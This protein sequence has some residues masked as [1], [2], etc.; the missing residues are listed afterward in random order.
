MSVI[1]TVVVL[2]YH[3]H[4]PNGGN[5]P[6]WVR[7]SSFCFQTH[8]ETHI[9]V[10]SWFRCDVLLLSAFI[11]VLVTVSCSA[12]L[13]SF[14]S[15]VRVAASFS[16]CFLVSLAVTH[17]AVSVCLSVFIKCLAA[18]YS[19]SAFQSALEKRGRIHFDSF[20]ISSFPL[21]R[22]EEMYH[23]TKVSALL[24]AYIKNWQASR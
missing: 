17:A 22:T 4:D 18:D 15:V 6:K 7:L 5:M 20:P 8:S 2:Q 21:F 19:R 3:H 10:S 12:T 24:G 23:Y 14:V 1:A 9:I 16:F 11:P 13:P